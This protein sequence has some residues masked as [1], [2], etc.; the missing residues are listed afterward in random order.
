[1]LQLLFQCFLQQVSVSQL[2]ACM[3]V[4]LASLVSEQAFQR[5]QS[6]GEGEKVVV[7]SQGEQCCVPSQSLQ[8]HAE[9]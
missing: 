9:Q 7:G 5:Q 1:M 4:A 2:S 8:V 6:Q 3:R